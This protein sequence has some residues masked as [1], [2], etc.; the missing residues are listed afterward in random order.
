M[1]SSGDTSSEDDYEAL[2][3]EV[4]GALGSKPVPAPASQPAARAKPAKAV[5]PSDDGG[6]DGVLS[7]L[8]AGLPVALLTGAGC[9]VVVWGVFAVLPFVGSFSGGAGAF[10]AGTVVSLA[11]RLR[12]R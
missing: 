7:R 2:L 6:D 1:P 10:I 12:R 9:G 4:E 8:E 11:G 5:V 3:R